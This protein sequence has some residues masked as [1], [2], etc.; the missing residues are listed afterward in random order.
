VI[1]KAFEFSLAHI[2][3]DI[4]AGSI[5]FDYIE[6]LKEA[7]VSNRCNARLFHQAKKGTGRW[8]M[9]S[10]AEDGQAPPDIPASSLYTFIQY[11]A[12]LARL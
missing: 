10:S 2:G 3:A 1:T 5:W 6:F 8:N 7:E 9:G 12:D 4:E 11:R